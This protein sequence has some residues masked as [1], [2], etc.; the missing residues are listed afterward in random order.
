MVELKAISKDEKANIVMDA[1]RMA[2]Q[3]GRLVK[4]TKYQKLALHEV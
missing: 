4:A 1:L 2:E 3:D